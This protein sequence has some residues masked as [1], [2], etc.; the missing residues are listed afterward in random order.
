MVDPPAL[1]GDEGAQACVGQKLA[2]RPVVAGGQQ[3]A[4]VA[5][6]VEHDAIMQHHLLPLRPCE[7][8]AAR[9]RHED[10]NIREEA[11]PRQPAVEGEGLHLV[12]KRRGSGG[13]AIGHPWA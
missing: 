3:A 6:E 11:H 10:R 4:A 13:H 2:H 12:Y 8:G 1:H 7:Q 5:G 9:L